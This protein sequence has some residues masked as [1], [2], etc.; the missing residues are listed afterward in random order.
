MALEDRVQA[1]RLLAFQR[2]Q[3]LGNA[4]AACR[5]LGSLALA[6]A[7]GPDRAAPLSL[8]PP[9]ARFSHEHDPT[10]VVV[11]SRP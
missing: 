10:R 6:V 9:H 5:E 2:A 4:S 1:L 3:K 8:V 11:F 7:G